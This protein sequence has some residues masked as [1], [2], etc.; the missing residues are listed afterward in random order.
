M[1]C[2]DSASVSD[3]TE[4]DPGTGAA[5]PASLSTGALLEEIPELA[6]LDPADP[7]PDYSKILGP[8]ILVADGSAAV[9]T[10][11]ETCSQL[12]RDQNVSSSRETS[13]VFRGMSS[14]F[15]NVLDPPEHTRIRGMVSRAFTPR[16]VE[17]LR[18]W[19]E[20]KVGD[21]LDQAGDEPYDVVGGLA[22][23]LPLV[24]I[25]QLLDIPDQDRDRVMG[26]SMPITFGA[27]LLVGRRSRDEQRAYRGALRAFRLYLQDLIERRASAP[28][29]DLISTLATPDQHGDRLGTRE[30][31]TTA[32]GL[33]IAGHETTVSTIAHGVL[34]MTRAP[35]LVE[36]VA[37]D[38]QFAES[39]VEEVLRYDTPVQATL[40][41]AKVGM[42]LDGVRIKAGCALL[43]LLGAANRDPRQFSEPDT[44]DVERTNNRTHLGFG[45]G[46]H[47]CVGASLGRLESVLALRTFAGRVREPR[48]APGGAVYAKSMMLRTLSSL[49]LEPIRAS[50]LRS[51]ST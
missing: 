38:E 29:D 15:F 32:M 26:W 50:T 4:T 6:G 2:I 39:F 30:I 12:L 45:A 13:P 9:I 17:L 43:L 42:R 3:L 7:Y 28:G 22:Y 25:C 47:F 5:R 31:I 23:P 11:F 16:S 19:L 18:P 51:T 34:A 40:R 14:S 41:V 10:R 46:P 35:E 44:F 48:V 37:E 24:A 49:T 20:G 1:S 36:A 27:D 8:P 21:L 33:L